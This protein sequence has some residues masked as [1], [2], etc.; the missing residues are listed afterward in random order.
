MELT[1]FGLSGCQGSGRL[2]MVASLTQTTAC[3]DEM[4]K[5]RPVMK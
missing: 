5:A 3:L 4:T 2:C 1:G